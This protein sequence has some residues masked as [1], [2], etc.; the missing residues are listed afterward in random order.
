M[1]EGK[2]APKELRNEKCNT[3]KFGN[4]CGLLLYLCMSLYF[5]GKIVVLDSGF[6]V[7]MALI[8]LKKLGVFAHAVIKKKVLA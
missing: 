6:C 8:E 7:L 5:T 2:D 4:T 3:N 1:C